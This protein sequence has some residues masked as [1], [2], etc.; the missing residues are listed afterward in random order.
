[1]RTEIY[2]LLPL[3]FIVSFLLYFQGYWSMLLETEFS[4]DIAILSGISS[5]LTMEIATVLYFWP[6]TVV[7]GSLFLTVTFYMLLGL[8]QAK[9]D[10]RLFSST[11]R[12]H[13]VVGVLVF[14]AMFFATHWGG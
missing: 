3:V 12:E 5:L 4:K 1:M 10:G 14:I 13:L 6:V 7:V 11:V 2:I 9:L 8:G